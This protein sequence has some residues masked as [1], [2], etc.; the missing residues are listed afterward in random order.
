MY[1]R[2]DYILFALALILLFSGLALLGG[3]FEKEPRRKHPGGPVPPSP[4]R[5]QVK[6]VVYGDQEPDAWEIMQERGQQGNRKGNPSWSE[7][8][9]IPG[10]RKSE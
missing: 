4:P 5:I 3:L 7:P 2:A 8:Q 1:T 10:R 9:S 6:E